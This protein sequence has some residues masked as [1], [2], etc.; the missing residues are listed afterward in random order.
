MNKNHFEQRSICTYFTLAGDIS[1]FDPNNASPQDFYERAEACAMAGF[2]GMGFSLDD[3]N[4]I[5]DRH[6]ASA[7]TQ[8]FDQLGM[9][10]REL[11]V[12]LDWFCT[13]ERRNIA[14]L[15]RKNMLRAA[16]MIGARQIKVVGDITGRV[17][18]FDHLVK[19]FAQLCDDAR[20]QGSAITIELYP[21]SNLADLQFCSNL[22]Q[23]AGRANGGL[24]LD[25]WHMVRGHQS[26]QAIA[27]LPPGI[28]NHVELD[29][30]NL[31]P[32]ADYAN[33]TINGRCVPGEGEFP[34]EQFMSALN[35][36]Q[37]DGLFGIEILSD[38]FRKASPQQ[39]ANAA[40]SGLQHAL[41]F[42]HQ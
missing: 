17:Y 29:D 4:A 28:I 32:S 21:T 20:S 13:D 5:L 33:D 24:L 27:S 35:S 18:P 22:V 36:C 41:Q 10:H 38:K 1:P 11:E 40:F 15:R 26:M 8:C 3:I 6:G 23:A 37:Y 42:F 31:L 2:N 14:N 39:A 16:G 30:G 12:L 9:Q 34:I 7:V 19:E 25:T